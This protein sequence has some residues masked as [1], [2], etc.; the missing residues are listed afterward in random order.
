[1]AFRSRPKGRESGCCT[2]QRADRISRDVT[3]ALAEVIAHPEHAFRHRVATELVGETG[4]V[5][6]VEL[7]FD[8]NMLRQENLDADPH[9]YLEMIRGAHRLGG[10]SADRR[11]DAA[12]LSE[13]KAGA[14]ASHAA[15]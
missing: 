9:M 14:R 4:H 7:R 12:A 3:S 8:E 11:S 2:G 10:C 5:V 6:Q 15:F 13:R 1:M